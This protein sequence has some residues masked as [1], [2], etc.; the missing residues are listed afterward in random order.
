MAPAIKYNRYLKDP[1]S[2]TGRYVHRAGNRLFES[3]WNGNY[4]GSG[5]TYREAARRL[6]PRVGYGG[7]SLTYYPYDNGA[8]GEIGGVTLCG[9]CALADWLSEPHTAFHVESSDSDVKYERAEYCDACNAV[10]E[11]QACPECGNAISGPAFGDHHNV[12]LG[13]FQCG[14][15]EIHAHCLARLVV[16]GSAVKAGKRTYAVQPYDYDANPR[17]EWFAGT[18]RGN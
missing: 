16:K 17:G 3:Y 6:F 2:T 15:R 13:R 4:E 14:Y 5:T 12:S 10:I 8:P 11:P 1:F 18:Y 9:D 7:Y